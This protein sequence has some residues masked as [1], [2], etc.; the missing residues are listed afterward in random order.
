MVY[1]VLFVIEV[2][3]FMVEMLVGIGDDYEGY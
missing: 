3:V 2:V 1:I